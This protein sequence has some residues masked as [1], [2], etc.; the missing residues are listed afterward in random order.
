[1]SG[2]PQGWVLEAVV[3]QDR[4]FAS[5][6]G[7][8]VVCEEARALIAMAQGESIRFDPKPLPRH[9]SRRRRKLR[10]QQVALIEWWRVSC[11]LRAACHHKAAER[12]AQVAR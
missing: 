8:E 3:A 6:A 2:E 10:A 7:L 12:L 9:V 5:R 4:V 1:M 11:R